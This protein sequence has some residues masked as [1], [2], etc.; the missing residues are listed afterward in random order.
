MVLAGN[1]A[2]VAE[3]WGL[4]ILN[5]VNP[6]NPTE[7]S[8]TPTRNGTNW[9]A[10]SG[11]QLYISESSY[12]FSVYDVSDPIAPLL[13][14]QTGILGSAQGLVLGG[15]HLFAASSEGGLQIFTETAESAALTPEL[16]QAPALPPSAPR[17]RLE[18]IRPVQDIP[19]IPSAPNRSADTCTV[20]SAADSGPGT[21]RECLWNQVSG[22]LIT[23]SPA[24]FPTANPTT[25]YLSGSVARRQPGQH[26]HRRI[27]CR[28]NPGWI[29]HWR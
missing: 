9:L 25:I 26:H 10:L 7:V 27:Q 12:G 5:V 21:L 28:R 13:T 19:A 6:A 18:L 22:D 4:R 11:S 29:Q 2:Y 16:T 23:F 20:T 8:F 14:S 15:G 17:R 3:S 1:Y 24:V